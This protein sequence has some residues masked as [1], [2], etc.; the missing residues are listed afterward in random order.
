MTKA[1]IRS[2]FKELPPVVWRTDPNFKSWTG[3]NPRSA[4]N[5][6]AKGEGPAERLRQ[7]KLVGYPRDSFVAWLAGRIEPDCKKAAQEAQ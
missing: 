2:L 3:L 6:D 5:L 7:G 1:E 4:A